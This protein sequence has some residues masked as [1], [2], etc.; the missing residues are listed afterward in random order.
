MDGLYSLVPYL[1]SIIAF[2]GSAYLFTRGP[3]EGCFDAVSPI[4][5][6]AVTI[7]TMGTYV[8]LMK[9]NTSPALWVPSLGA[10]IALGVY[11]SWSTTLEMRPDGSLRTVRTMWYLA[12]LAA[13]IGIS[14]L[15]IRQ[16][17]LNR[18]MFHGGLA[19]F[20]FGTATAAASNV[21]LL[22]RAASLK[23]TTL[24]EIFA[25]LRA[26]NWREGTEGSPWQRFRERMASTGPAAGASPP[27]AAASSTPRTTEPRQPTPAPP[28]TARE[29]RCPNCGT[30]AIADYK[31]CRNCGKPLADTSTQ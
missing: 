8:G 10:G 24:T 12:V 30:I 4:I 29:I 18:G 14:Q 11:G 28:E 27:P 5:Q 2:A 31:F 7:A 13:T 17:A 21:T 23:K 20:Y 26:F 19:A 1:A 15:L 22:L 3:K 9:V 16:S 6:T 25:P